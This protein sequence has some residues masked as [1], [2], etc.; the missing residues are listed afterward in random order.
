MPQTQIKEI[1][2]HS[3]TKNLFELGEGRM[4]TKGVGSMISTSAKIDGSDDANMKLESFG[5]R[6]KVKSFK[7]QN[8]ITINL[9]PSNG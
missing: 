7:L 5:D 1:M 3:S 6:T 9:R 8:V 2:K 4:G